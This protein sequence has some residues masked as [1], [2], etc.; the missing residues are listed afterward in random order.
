MSRFNVEI[1]SSTVDNLLSQLSK[2]QIHNILFTAIKKGGAELK[3]STYENLLSTKF[4]VKG[5]R[6]NF[7]KNIKQKNN[8]LYGESIISIGGYLWWFEKGTKERTQ[9]NGR[10][11]GHITGKNFFK[12]AQQNESRYTEPII[13]SIE[14]TMSNILN[15]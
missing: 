8:D 2:E 7:Q 13:S 12:K 15:N 10:N 5:A 1:D 14:K 9:R 4:K 3:K 11:T 6:H